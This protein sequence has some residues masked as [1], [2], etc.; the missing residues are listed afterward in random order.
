MLR[1]SYAALGQEPFTCLFGVSVVVW[2]VKPSLGVPMPVSKD[3]LHYYNVSRK[4]RSH[5][6]FQVLVVANTVSKHEA[7]VMLTAHAET[8]K[9]EL[10]RTVIYTGGTTKYWLRRKIIPVSA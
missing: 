4:D 5:Y 8:G 10:A 2:S 6:E 3:S 1:W 7:R 9:W